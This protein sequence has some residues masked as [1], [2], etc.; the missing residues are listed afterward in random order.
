[1]KNGKTVVILGCG[2]AGLTCGWYLLEKGYKVLLIEKEDRCGGLC[3]TIEYQGFRFDLGGHRFISSN[4]DLISKVKDLL[5]EDILVRERKSIIKLD[6]QEFA[7]PINA[8]DLLTKLGLCTIANITQDLVYKLFKRKRLEINSLEDWCIEKFGQTIYSKFF[9]FYNE[10]LWGMSPRDISSDWAG[11]RIPALNIEDLLIALL[12]FRTK[13]I[14]TFAKYYLYP[15]I[16]IGAIFDCITEIIIKKG[17]KI[18]TASN[19]T[20][21]VCKNSAI[22]KID[23]T[24]KGSSLSVDCDYL[25]ST[26]PLSDLIQLFSDDEMFFEL[27]KWAV[28]LK[29]RSL[30]FV[31]ILIDEALISNNTW[32]YIPQKDIIFTRIQEPKL[33][34]P[35]MAPQNKTSLMLEIPCNKGDL[36]WNMGDAELFVKV[37]NGLKMLDININKKNVL[38]FFSTYAEHA[39]PI[40]KRDYSQNR[41]RILE[42]FITRY[43]NIILCG[44]QGTFNYLFMDFAMLAGIQAAK[45][46]LKETPKID[47]WEVANIMNFS[48]FIEGKSLI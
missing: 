11:Q 10:K 33:R 48:E 9:K 36:I 5:K 27:N 8:R 13:K 7:Y 4:S 19:L 24:H 3:K 44:R 41:K 18:F 31:N 40:Y 32:Q 2:P 1:M 22:Q 29:D 38:G 16:G 23:F 37:L 45:Y 12:G 39:Y 20:N 42:F 6:G 21:V 17:G 28:N 34:S 46:I 15:K 43:K 35:L 30:R 47:R 14:R 25:I 26:I